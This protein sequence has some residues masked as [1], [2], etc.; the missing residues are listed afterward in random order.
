MSREKIVVELTA[1]EV[2][3]IFAGLHLVVLALKHAVRNV[4][5]A[6]IVEICTDR[7]KNELLSDGGLDELRERLKAA[8]PAEVGTPL[9]KDVAERLHRW[10]DKD[11][12][13]D[14]FVD[15]FLNAYDQDGFAFGERFFYNPETGKTYRTQLTLEIEDSDPP[16][17]DTCPRCGEPTADATD[18]PDDVICDVCGWSR[19]GVRR[20]VRCGS[21]EDLV[22]D[23]AVCTKCR[24]PGL[25]DGQGGGGNG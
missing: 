4:G 13:Y 11:N 23:D 6:D 17:E 25:G 12:L 22:P 20:C 10:G 5:W 8:P 16:D 2:G 19:S 14:A 15:S 18:I 21:R 7:G 9:P 1:Q 24:A 3:H